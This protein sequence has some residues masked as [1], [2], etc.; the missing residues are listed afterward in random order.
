MPYLKCHATPLLLSVII[1]ILYHIHAFGTINNGA[2]Y[3]TEL[4]IYVRIHKLL[5]FGQL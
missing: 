5:T 2:V 3:S 4:L 1:E